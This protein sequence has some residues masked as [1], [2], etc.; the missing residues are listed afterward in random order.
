MQIIISYLEHIWL[1]TDR[2]DSS[3]DGQ[4]QIIVD[5][6]LGHGGGNA[7]AE[8]VV[9]QRVDVVGRVGG[10]VGVGHGCFIWEKKG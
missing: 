3:N 7:A 10:V 1:K 8:Q 2:N 5:I 6:F 4:C 9:G